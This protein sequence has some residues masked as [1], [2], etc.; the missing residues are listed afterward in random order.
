LSDLSSWPSLS[1]ALREFLDEMVEYQREQYDA[2]CR[3][4]LHDIET[5]TLS[6]K[7]GSQVIYFA[8]GKD[9]KVRDRR[10]PTGQIKHSCRLQVSYNP[11]LV[12]LFNEVRMLSV[13]GFAVPAKINQATDLAKKFAKQAKALEQIASFHNTIGDRMIA[14]QV[15]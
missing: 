7:T 6:L 15:R 5:G 10:S 2:W 12:G 14:S 9:M 1:S 3:D 13:L 8:E 4:T 11:R